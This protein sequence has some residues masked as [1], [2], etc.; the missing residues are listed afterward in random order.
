VLEYEVR[1]NEVLAREKQPAIC[2]YDLRRL[3]GS[4]MLDIMRAH[5]LT[6][7]NGVVHRNQFFT[8]PDAFLAELR[9][10]TQDAEGS[11]V[12]LA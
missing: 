10:R 6:L 8:P 5:P 12:A 3:S 1:V 11:Q 7:V 2:V 4:M 9:G